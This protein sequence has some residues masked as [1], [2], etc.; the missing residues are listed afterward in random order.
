MGVV[1]A[2]DLTSTQLSGP[3]RQMRR[4]VAAESQL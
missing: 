1:I 3:D 2:F 4:T